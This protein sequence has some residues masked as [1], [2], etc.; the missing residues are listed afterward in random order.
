MFSEFILRIIMVHTQFYSENRLMS[1]FLKKAL[2]TF[3]R[4]SVQFLLLFCNMSS[5]WSKLGNQVSQN[6]C[7]FHKQSK[8]KQLLFSFGKNNRKRINDGF[9]TNIEIKVKVKG[10]LTK[11]LNISSKIMKVDILLV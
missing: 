7:P 8:I 2:V 10:N 4:N 9:G 1:L 11:T 5:F 3:C 6:I